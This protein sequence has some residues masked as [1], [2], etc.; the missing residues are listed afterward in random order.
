[1]A[2]AAL[3]VYRGRVHTTTVR[4]SAETWQDLKD[5]CERDGVATAQYIREAT[6]ARLA[7]SAHAPRTD[8]LEHELG[9]LRLR[10]E[11]LEYLLQR[12]MT[13]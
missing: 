9:E 1:M 12:R 8:R 4:F 3:T 10:V 6:I 11:R 5:A 13:R 7:Q 2:V